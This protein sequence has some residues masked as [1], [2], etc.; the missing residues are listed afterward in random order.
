MVNKLFAVVS[1]AACE[2]NLYKSY[3]VV[4]GVFMQEE[5]AV[6]HCRKRDEM[7][8]LFPIPPGEP[9]PCFYIWGLKGEEFTPL[10]YSLGKHSEVSLR[11][12]GGRCF[13]QKKEY[14]EQD[15]FLGFRYS[16]GLPVKL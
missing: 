1:F 11:A 10:N 6:S 5:L 14:L 2:D 4:E 9:W 15:V 12:I 7:Q 13:F 3:M 8:F 16:L